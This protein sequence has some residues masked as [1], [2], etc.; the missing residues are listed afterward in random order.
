MGLRPGRCYHWDS[1]AYTRVAKNPQD[2]FITGIPGS[3][4]VH[5]NMG[6]RSG[7]F[8]TEI[9]IIC[10]EKV[11]IRHNA[12]EAARISANRHLERKIGVSSYMFKVRIYPHHVMRENV[13]ATGAGADRVQS[14]MRRSFGKP[15]G[16]TAR[17]NKN[18]L[19]FSVY[20]DK[21][22]DA[23]VDVKR[24]LYLAIRKLPGSL[25]IV[26]R[27]VK[28]K[29]T[30]PRGIKPKGTDT[31]PVDVAPEETDIKS[32]D[33]ASGDIVMATGDIK[34]KGDATTTNIKVK[35]TPPLDTDPVTPDTKPKSITSKTTKPKSI[36]SKTTKP[37][38]ITSKT[39]KPKSITSKST[40]PK[41]TKPKETKAKDD[42]KASGAKAKDTKAKSATTKTD[43]GTKGTKAKGVKK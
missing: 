4:I 35:D 37:K 2:S 23:I 10:N 30:K 42:T 39:T 31:K 26:I 17:V 20:V 36:T 6:N 13:M 5:F 15:M 24:A 34:V 28:P 25:S 12:I 11:Q 9:S 40:N 3:K 7:E 1:P 14:G 29:T 22:E 18:Q 8:N 21:T 16:V 33:I 41:S 19:V 32:G 27:D 43:A 38:S